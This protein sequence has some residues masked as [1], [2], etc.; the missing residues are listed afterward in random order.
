MASKQG[1]DGRFSVYT[2]ID[3]FSERM[4]KSRITLWKFNKRVKAREREEI[5]YE[6]NRRR[7]Q[8]EDCPVIFVHG[9][10]IDQHKIDRYLRDQAKAVA[11]PPL[12]QR[13]DLS[14]SRRVTS[15]MGMSLIIEQHLEHMASFQTGRATPPLLTR[16]VTASLLDIGSLRRQQIFDRKTNR[17]NKAWRIQ[18]MD[19]KGLLATPGG[20]RAVQIRS[21]HILTSLLRP[22]FRDALQIAAKFPTATTRI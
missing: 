19:P 7:L 12:Q 21:L 2:E 1:E 3:W 18:K 6:W 5:I 14:E 9:R 15:G 10:Q 8:G 4:F 11:A 16:F 17:P 20:L 13:C 22:Y